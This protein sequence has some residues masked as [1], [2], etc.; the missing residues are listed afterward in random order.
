MICTFNIATNLNLCNVQFSNLPYFWGRP[1]CCLLA[2]N[3]GGLS[4]FSGHS[5]CDLLGGGGQSGTEIIFVSEYFR[6][7][8][9]GVPLML[10]IS[11]H[12]IHTNVHLF[13]SIH[14]VWCIKY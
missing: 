14:A 13:M 7:S 6:L 9:S 3:C 11:F 5:M 4:L 8:L 10:H 1:S 12:N 2:S